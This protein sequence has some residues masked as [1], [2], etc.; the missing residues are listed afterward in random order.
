VS[1]RETKK[2]RKRKRERKLEKRRKEKEKTFDSRRRGSPCR[3]PRGGR[4][5]SARP[6]CATRRRR[7][8]RPVFFFFFFFVGRKRGRRKEVEEVGRNR[9][10]EFFSLLAR[11]FFSPFSF[12]SRGSIQAPLRSIP[13]PNRTL[14]EIMFEADPWTQLIAMR[15]V[16]ALSSDA[17]KSQNKPTKRERASLSTKKKVDTGARPLLVAAGLH[18]ELVFDAF[19]AVPFFFPSR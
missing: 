11:C 12:D 5:W 18:C 2:T 9:V 13:S 15:S 8:P 6:S 17:P 1:E 4:P 7:F 10:R 14:P 19:R 3:T 16:T